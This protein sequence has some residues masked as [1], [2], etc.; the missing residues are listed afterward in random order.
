MTYRS[1]Q[2]VKA[3]LERTNLVKGNICVVKEGSC[4]VNRVKDG[5][6]T[7]FRG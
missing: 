2:A 5:K 1:E 3:D 6:G 4:V 7:D